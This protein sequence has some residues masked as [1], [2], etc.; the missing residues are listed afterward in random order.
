MDGIFAADDNATPLTEEEKSGLKAKWITLRSELNELEASN[1]ASAMKWLM[2]S[3][4]K[5]ILNATFLLKLHKKMFGDVWNW[6]GTFR[7]TEK[8]IGVAPYQ[9]SVKLQSLFEDTRFWLEN[10]T[11]SP[12]EIVVRFHHKLV[13]IHPFP[14]VNGRISR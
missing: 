10:K 13:A 11:Y 9:I 5:D 3:S 1:I 4:P 2:V 7:T 12:L 8:N 6:A 14:N